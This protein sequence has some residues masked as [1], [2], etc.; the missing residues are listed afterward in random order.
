M[1]VLSESVNDI[2]KSMATNQFHC[3]EHIVVGADTQFV[4][5]NDA[6]VLELGGRFRSKAAGYA[7][8]SGNSIPQYIP[9]KG[10]LAMIRAA[11]E[12]RR[13]EGVE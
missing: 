5:W 12:L 13:R 11:Q 1:I 10:Y 4:D 7:L 6:G 9:L 2:L 8:G 3:I